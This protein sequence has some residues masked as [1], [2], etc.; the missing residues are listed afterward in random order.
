VCRGLGF[1]L[2]W[3][4]KIPTRASLGLTTGNVWLGLA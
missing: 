1:A 3:F 2:M 4:D